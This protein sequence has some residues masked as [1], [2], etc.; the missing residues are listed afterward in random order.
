M[1]QLSVI[2]VHGLHTY[3]IYF[4]ELMKFYASKGH[5]VK[6]YDLV[7]FGKTTST[8][9]GD[10][11]SINVFIFQLVNLIL[12]IRKLRPD[13]PITVIGEDIG[14]LIALLTAARTE[15]LV[16]V[17]I[18]VNPVTDAHYPFMKS[19]SVGTFVGGVLN[20]SRRLEMCVTPEQIC[21]DSKYL[22]ILKKD[23]NRL[24]YVTFRFWVSLMKATV[25]LKKEVSRIRT[26]CLV[27]V[28]RS[29]KNPLAKIT[30][31]VFYGIGARQKH[32]QLLDVPEAMSIC[33]DRDSVFQKQL[34]FI[35]SVLNP[36]DPADLSKF[37]DLKPQVKQ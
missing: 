4:A 9:R 11:E 23:G 28:S 35:D 25:E 8:G 10:T 29:D 37:P 27:Q 26:P 34:K 22:E 36:P 13:Y 1:K 31:D 30:K 7:G 32:F 33:K 14:G 6:T 20:P 3:H 15:K 16:D 17:L 24:G 2:A 19:E 18:A 5:E 12:E 21:D